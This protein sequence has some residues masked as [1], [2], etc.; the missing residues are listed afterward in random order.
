VRGWERREWREDSSGADECES[1]TGIK[2]ESNLRQHTA[3]NLRSRPPHLD[4]S[5]AASSVPPCLPPL[6]PPS[7]CSCCC[8]ALRALDEDGKHEDEVDIDARFP[9]SSNWTC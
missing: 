5:R 2:T 8:C 1:H 9:L 6:K 7:C 3:T 4:M